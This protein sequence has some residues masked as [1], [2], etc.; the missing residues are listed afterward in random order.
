M[1]E[2]INEHEPLITP[3][4]SSRHGHGHRP[5]P[6]KRRSRR[7][8]SGKTLLFMLMLLVL[9]AVF[10]FFMGSRNWT[11]SSPRDP[12]HSP[13]TVK[14]LRMEESHP[15]PA[16][17]PKSWE[18]KGECKEDHPFVL[19]LALKQQNT[20]SLE[21]H[22]ASVS[23]PS[24]TATFHKYW[25]AERVRSTFKPSDEAL[26]SVVEWLNGNGF[27]VENGKI[28]MVSRYGNVI[29]VYLTCGDA[30]RLLSTK[31]MFYQNKNGKETHLRVKDGIYNIP[32]AIFQY[33]D[34]I[35][36]TIRFPV[37]RHTLSVQTMDPLHAQRVAKHS[38]DQFKRQH[39]VSHALHLQSH[40]DDDKADSEWTESLESLDSE[41]IEDIESDN[42]SNDDMT[43]KETSKETKV[44]ALNDVDDETSSDGMGH[45]GGGG[46]D[47]EGNE[48]T[49]NV[50]ARLYEL[51]DMTASMATILGSDDVDTAQCRQAVASFIEQY[52]N[53]ED[54]ETFWENL[55][56]YPTSEM[57]RI[58]E[59]QP[60]GYGSEAELDTQYITS[61]GKGIFT[62]VYYIDSDDIFVS[63]VEQI[64]ATEVPPLV[65]SISYGA[66]EYELGED[67]VTRCNE[68]F[69]KLA[70]IG[71]TVL[72]SSGDSGIRGNDED[73][74][75]GDI[76]NYR[77][78]NGGF[79]RGRGG[80]GYGGN[81]GNS[82]ESLL[83]SKRRSL[84]GHHDRSTS[85]RS[86]SESKDQDEEEEWFE[87]GLDDETE[88]E[89][90]YSFIGSFPASAP[91]VTAVGGTEGGLV[92]D[93]IGTTTGETAW[94]YSGG[95]FSIY[96]PTPDWQQD[97]VS[98]YLN[99]N[100]ITFPDESRFQSTGRAYPD[101]SAQSVDYVIAY[102]SA[103]YLVSG[104]SA[105]SPAVAGMI[106]MINY[107]RLKEGKSSLGFLNPSLYKLY[108]EEPGYYFNDVLEG[109]N[110]G[111]EV[112]D[113]I[114]FFA[115]EGWDPITGVGTPKFS[116][117]YSALMALD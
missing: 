65:V 48:L 57:E 90:T 25:S 62:Y 84:L 107:G 98:S 50:P 55:D 61:T 60:E 68:E 92:Q 5:R 36:P 100:D 79:G 41:H 7:S 8:S 22:V 93:D 24:N 39:T 72:A 15:R 33:I 11:G 108:A 29:R 64:L 45:G 67:W 4:H 102:D 113:D 69:G 75:Q 46:A 38:R 116:R 19:T 74:L 110:I 106:S 23:H 10:V 85:S 14:W 31:Y 43:S 86:H 82:Q 42:I 13:S 17:I 53:D 59:D 3:H 66:D 2:P 117:L 49:A 34:F 111:C 96:F 47:G 40:S 89:D 112:D 35:S 20:D 51:Y 21:E 80:N 52:Y 77:G 109:H 30:N 56:V 26:E 27:S 78:E 58:P 12:P 32:S 71:T 54:I 81:N 73:C 18:Q 83:G 1:L 70:L 94:L 88:D 114:G 63:L 37:E 76:T 95:G 28:Q 9:S 101:I 105:S 104:T 97:A 115:A 91:Y 6:T 16:H 44:D 99:R 103:F 87:E